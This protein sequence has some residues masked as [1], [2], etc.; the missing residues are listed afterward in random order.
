M[1]R[2]LLAT[3][4]T[5][6]L[7]LGGLFTPQNAEAQPWRYRSGYAYGP[8]YGGYYQPYTTYRPNYYY[9]SPRYYSGYYGAPYYSPNYYGYRSYYGPGYSYGYPANRSAGVYLGVPGAG[10]YV[11]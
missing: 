3:A 5:L 2:F 8:Y 6:T 10:V 11:R 9:P 4:A 7:V 1:K